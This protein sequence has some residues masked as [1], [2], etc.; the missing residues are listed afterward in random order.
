MDYPLSVQRTGD[1]GG[2]CVN[3][4]FCVLKTTVLYAVAS[5]AAF[6]L[7]GYTL[8][9][10]KLHFWPETGDFDALRPNKLHFWP[11]TGGLDALNVYRAREV[12]FVYGTI[13]L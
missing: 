5:F 10:K 12:D 2:R 6:V 4:P 11:E 7:S 9:P 8:R 3:F 13:F 1:A